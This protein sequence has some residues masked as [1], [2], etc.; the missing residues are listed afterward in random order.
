MT[1]TET[2]TPQVETTTGGT[3]WVDICNTMAHRM[4]ESGPLLKAMREVKE[5]YEGDWVLPHFEDMGNLTPAIIADA[6]DHTAM[7]AAQM[8]PSIMCPPRYGHVLTGAGSKA[9]ADIRRKVLVG[10]WE[11]SGLDVA[12]GR[13]YRH[14][15][16]YATC[17]LITLPD[18]SAECMKV[19]VRDPL[20]TFPEPK[21]A[22][23]LSPPTNIGFV[24][25]RSAAYLRATFPKSRQENGGPIPHDDPATSLWDTVE[26]WDPD[27]MVVGIMGP[28]EEQR[29][30]HAGDTP[31][32]E[33]FRVPNRIG[34]VPAVV[35][36]RVTLG[37]VLSQ[38]S[39]I[40][41][42][43]DLAAKL[44]ALDVIAAEKAI[45][46]DRYIIG[47]GPGTVPTVVGGTWQDG[48][49]G[50]VNLLVDASQ[51]G[52]MRGT[53]DPAGKIAIDRLERNA[54]KS[55]GLVPQ[56]TGESYG[57]MRTG[58]AID[59]LYAAAVDPRVHELHRIFEHAA[60]TLNRAV[61][62]GYKAWWG[63]EKL[64]MFTGWRGDDIVEFEPA[65]H[66]DITENAV[67][68]SIPGADVQGT[69]IALGQLLAAEGISKETFRAS[70]PWIDDAAREEA[71]IAV[72][73]LTSA[74]MDTLL[75]RAALP[76]DQGGIPPID[77]VRILDLLRKDG[78]IVAAVTEA[79]RLAQERQAAMAPPPEEEQ[80][81]AP[82][83][84]PGLAGPGEG[85]EMAPFE[86]PQSIAGPNDSQAALRQLTMALKT[87][88]RMTV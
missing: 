55:S 53:P 62:D 50:Q 22:E 14:L 39:N 11:K 17:S 10:T 23:D 44:A 34:Y 56:M 74:V 83:E 32:K 43:V 19:H 63:E 36:T 37:R 29:R 65:K 76:P 64:T 9:W 46:P 60:P 1:Y 6:I 71:Q 35:P 5:R 59:S 80:V 26:W 28:R 38:V 61:L 68:Y 82:E 79:D 7:Q 13:V 67:R 78:D 31:H 57:A 8:R 24:Y 41:G 66:F 87:T 27:V 51:V 2:A 84:M 75:Q 33:L 20:S 77:M 21:A 45:F 88:P 70:H 18:F 15:A 72:E 40:V 42:Q 81:A 48:R 25:G 54:S 4:K 86:P 16:G 12:M 47:A 69:T 3:S 58:R 52:E 49:T 85:A 30:G 73:K